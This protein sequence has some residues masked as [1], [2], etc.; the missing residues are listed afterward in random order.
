MQIVLY[1]SGTFIYQTQYY[2]NHIKEITQARASVHRSICYSSRSSY[3]YGGILY[4]TLTMTESHSDS[5]R[6]TIN[7][8]E[9]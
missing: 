4:Y 2:Y 1:G 6:V 5:S 8:Q 9:T 7:G 3:Y